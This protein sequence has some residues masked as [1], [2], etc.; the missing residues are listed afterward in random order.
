MMSRG[1]DYAIDGRRF[2]LMLVVTN[3]RVFAYQED[4]S[5]GEQASKLLS[6]NPLNL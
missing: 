3:D 4:G 2:C 5:G 6:G 1:F